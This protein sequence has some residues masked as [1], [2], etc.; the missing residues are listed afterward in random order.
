MLF[1]RYSYDVSWEMF[2]SFCGKWYIVMGLIGIP[3]LLIT[4]TVSL[5]RGKKDSG[6]PS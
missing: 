6:R 5:V 1:Q 3:M 4:L 2:V